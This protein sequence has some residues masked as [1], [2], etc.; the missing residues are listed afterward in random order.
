MDE[1]PPSIRD[2]IATL[3]MI[4]TFSADTIPE[5]L[6]EAVEMDLEPFPGMFMRAEPLSTAPFRFG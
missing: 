4:N 5:H 6:R 2:L 1:L 3:D